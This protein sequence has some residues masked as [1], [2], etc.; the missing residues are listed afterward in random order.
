MELLLLFTTTFALDKLKLKV[1]DLDLTI[2]YFNMNFKF[3]AALVRAK[4]SSL[5]LL[6]QINIIKI[7]DYM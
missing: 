6:Y 1:I 7:T 4:H 2:F 3:Y 5:D